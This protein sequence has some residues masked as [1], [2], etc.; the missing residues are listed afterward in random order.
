MVWCGARNGR[1]SSRPAP[2]GRTPATLWTLVVSSASSKVSGGRMAASRLASMVLPEPGGP[3]M[4][5]LW[6]PAAATSS[7]RL[8]V[9]WPRTSPKSSATGRTARGARPAG[10]DGGSELVRAAPADATASARCRTPKTRTPS[11]TAAS[12]AFSAG[13]IRFANAVARARTPPSEARRAPAGSRR[14]A[15][16]RPPAG[17]RWSW[18]TAPMAPRMPRA[19]GR[20]KPAPSLRTLAG[21]QVD[22]DGLVG[23]AEA[24]V[25]ERRLD[26]LAALPHRRVGHADHDEVARRSR[27]H[28]CPPRHR[29]GEHRCHKRRRCGCGKAAIER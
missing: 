29:S 1:S 11:T 7:A 25:H 2:C 22:G 26:A 20:S 6:P 10:G 5:T 12:A 3:I 8:A 23:V 16:A 18:A 17:A 9:A 14:R 27:T 28:T 21:R 24:G 19:M 4:S 15:T 13:T